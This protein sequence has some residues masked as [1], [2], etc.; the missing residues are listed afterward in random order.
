MKVLSIAC[1][2]SDINGIPMGC[3]PINCSLYKLYL[4]SIPRDVSPIICSPCELYPHM[5]FLTDVSQI[6]I[7]V[8]QTVT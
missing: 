5:A 4:L 3:K 2:A 6:S 8:M 1:Y 7:F